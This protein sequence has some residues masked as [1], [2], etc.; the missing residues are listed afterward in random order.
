MSDDVASQGT[1]CRTPAPLHPYPTGRKNAEGP[2]SVP[3]RGASG[4][5]LILDIHV[6]Q[7]GGGRCRPHFPVREDDSCRQMTPRRIQRRSCAT[8]S[9]RA[10]DGCGGDAS[11]SM[12]TAWSS[13]DGR[14]GPRSAVTSRLA[15]SSASDLQPK[16]H[17]SC[18]HATRTP[19]RCRWTRPRS[20]RAPFVRS[21]PVSIRQTDAVPQ[22]PIQRS[23]KPFS[24]V[25]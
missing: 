22:N 20:G 17:W 23:L 11:A 24:L 4:A 13:P 19:C 7:G 21:G 2:G 16:A 12:S 1:F 8:H 5:S 10:S 9:G 25:Q 6:G 18:V 3:P 14:G 15:G